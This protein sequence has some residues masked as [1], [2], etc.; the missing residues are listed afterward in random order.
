MQQWQGSLRVCKE[1]RRQVD[2]EPQDRQ[3]I[4]QILSEINNP[5][6]TVPQN[7]EKVWKAG[8]EGCTHCHDGYKGRVGLFEAIIVDE[9][10]DQVLRTHPSEAEIRN[11]AKPQ[12]ILSMQQDG[13]LKILRGETT[14]EELRR[15][16]DLKTW[17]R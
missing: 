12:K 16:I 9:S 14:L 8:G 11:A 1:C 5:D 6:V 2:I 17:E 13:V 4:E 10:I 3:L 15:M 7:I